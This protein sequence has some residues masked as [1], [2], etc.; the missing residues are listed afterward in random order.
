MD[1]E[2]L[3]DYQEIIESMSF[4]ADY[5]GEKVLNTVL[6]NYRHLIDEN[7]RI[8][9]KVHKFLN[10]NEELRNIT[11]EQRKII[12]YCKSHKRIFPREVE[13]LLDL[14]LEKEEIIKKAL[15]LFNHKLPS[16]R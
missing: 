7:P 5:D 12:E 10:F 9:K 6:D 11:I 1:D 14:N 16:K 4:I 8:K 13:R 15:K 3:D 2:E